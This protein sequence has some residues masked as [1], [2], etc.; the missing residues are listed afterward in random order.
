MELKQT[1]QEEVL[2]I[3]LKES[4][5]F[6]LWDV[7]Y[8]QE[9]CVTDFYCHYRNMIIASLKKKGNIILWQNSKVLEE[10]EQL[11]PTFEEL[12]LTVVLLLIDSRL[13]GHIKD[14]YVHLI[15]KGESVMDF[16]TEILAEVTAFFTAQESKCTTLPKK[17][18][19]L[20]SRYVS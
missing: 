13:P 16:K 19:D 8:K 14:E 1:Q 10:D 6:D 18:D 15:G 11:S 3:P 4:H 20:H 7:Q 2:G 12:I 17:D 9:T 5:F